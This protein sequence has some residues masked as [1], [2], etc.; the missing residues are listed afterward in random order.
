MIL[1]RL[2]HK[3]NRVLKVS[4]EV[5]ERGDQVVSRAPLVHR[6]LPD[7]PALVVTQVNKVIPVQRETRGCVDLLG[8]LVLPELEETMER[9][10]SPDRQDLVGNLEH[11]ECRVYQVF[12]ERLDSQEILV[13]LVSRV[14]PVQQDRL[15]LPEA[16][17][18]LDK[19]ELL[20]LQEIQASKDLREVQVI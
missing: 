7:L 19:L 3:D 10:D 17:E 13:S 15:V 11:K 2:D 1:V 12:P 5:K 14:Q 6:G 4:Q 16:L 18:Q 9:Q 20:E 8:L